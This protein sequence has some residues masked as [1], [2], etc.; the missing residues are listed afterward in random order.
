MLLISDIF[1]MKSKII[2]HKCITVLER[3]H[4]QFEI[5]VKYLITQKLLLNLLVD[6]GQLVF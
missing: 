2:I 3:N 1:M 4:V 6:I 5:N